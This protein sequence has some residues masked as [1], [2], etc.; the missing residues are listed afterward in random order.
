MPAM[1]GHIHAVAHGGAALLV[2]GDFLLRGLRLNVF[3]RQEFENH[4]RQEYGIPS[5][6]RKSASRSSPELLDKLL[7]D[8]T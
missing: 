6:R 7:A 1:A 5:S 8:G 2:K 4:M 3:Q